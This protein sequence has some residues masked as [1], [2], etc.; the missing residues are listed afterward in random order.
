M[1]TQTITTTGIARTTAVG[2][3]TTVQRAIQVPCTS[4]Q[5]RCYIGTGYDCM[6]W[7]FFYPNCTNHN[8]YCNA[9]AGAYVPAITVC[10]QRLI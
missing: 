5:F 4:S 6:T 7:K 2:S 9:S 3:N 8:L 1:A 10:T